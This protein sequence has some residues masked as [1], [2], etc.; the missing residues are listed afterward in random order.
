MVTVKN[1][2]KEF[3]SGTKALDNISFHIH[4]GET[5]G[6][7]GANGAGKTTLI[8]LISGLLKPDGGFVRVFGDNPLG[9]TGKSRPFAGVV[10][11]QQITV[12]Y[13]S[14]RFTTTVLQDNLTVE[15]NM[16]LVKAIYKIPDE[17][18]KAKLKELCELLDIGSFWQY[19]ADRLSLGQRMRAELAAVL[20]YEPEL[21]ILDEPFIGIDLPSKDA[22][23]GI[24]QGIAEAQNATI[25][26]T[27]HDLEEIEKICKRVILLDKG[28]TVFNGNL[29]HIKYF[30]ANINTLSATLTDKI[31]DM[32]D[33]PVLKYTIENRKITVWYDSK[34]VDTRDLTS[35]ILS[36]TKISDLLIKKP[37]IEEI[38]KKIYTEEAQ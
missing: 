25:I 24:L 37:S 2:C 26:L 33:F 19:R 3:Q 31:P 16:K 23:R 14:G 35:Y 20:L 1:L 4:K 28:K 34:T 15:M 22:I 30:F 38:V 5:V 18:Y 29:E 9:R 36:Q 8:K 13:E 11:G 7:I 21:I 27:T 17:K 32:Q 12:G 6:L 10:S